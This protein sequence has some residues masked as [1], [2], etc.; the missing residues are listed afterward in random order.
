MPLK[1]SWS[2]FLSVHHLVRL[3]LV[4]GAFML[5]GAILT[6]GIYLCVARPDG[7]AV[8]FAGGISGVLTAV[9]FHWIRAR[10]SGEGP[11]HFME[12]IHNL[13]HI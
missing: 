9:A 4:Y 2:R 3:L 1:M 6:F 7:I 11:A 8:F 10:I 13:S 5:V 12:R